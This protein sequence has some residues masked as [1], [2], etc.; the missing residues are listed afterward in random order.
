MKNSS[1]IFLVYLKRKTRDFIIVVNIVMF[2]AKNAGKEAKT[3][4][5]VKI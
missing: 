5:C 1:S 4:E 2:V 3:D